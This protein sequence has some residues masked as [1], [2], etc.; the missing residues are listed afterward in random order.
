LRIALEKAKAANMPKDNIERAIA[1][2]DKSAGA[3]QLEEVL[4]EIYG[5]GGVALLAE[6]VTDNHNRTLG[7]VRATLNKFGGKLA[8]TGA[9]SYLFARK[10]LL[11]LP[12]TPEQL[13]DLG[14]KVIESGA[15]DIQPEEDKLLVIT[16]PSQLETVRQ[17]ILNQG[18]TVEEATLF[19]QAL[20][21]LPINDENR[22]KLD[23]LAGALED[24]ADITEVV[25]NYQ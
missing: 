8:N 18:I 16:E 3:S 4:F 22:T 23:R 17:D 25:C 12:A 14:L 9:V 21:P 7:E 13:D 2:G 19:W 24:L 6:G 20:N 15:K 1:R 5:P 10:G 11:V